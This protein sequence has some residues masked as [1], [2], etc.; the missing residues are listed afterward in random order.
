MPQR[1]VDNNSK[2]VSFWVMFSRPVA[3]LES[4]REQPRWFYPTLFSAVISAVVNLYLIQRVGL[5]SLINAVAQAETVFDQEALAQNALAHRGQILFFQ[6]AATFFSS[7][8]I[9]LLTAKVLWL[10]LT[11]FGYDLP[12]K[13]TLAVVAHANMLS[14]I[15][16]EGMIA[17]AATIIQDPGALDLKNPLATNVAFFLHPTSPILFRILASLDL[18]TLVNIGLLVI[19]LTKVA[20]KLSLRSASMTV[21]IPWVIYVGAT[22]LIPV[23]A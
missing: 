9:A 11:L 20:P 5:S 18:I 3:T 4:L 14:V 10:L 15:L 12:F 16:R 6:S 13:K 7:F 1:S 17:A 22:L 19:G 8:L 2:P 23:V 21:V